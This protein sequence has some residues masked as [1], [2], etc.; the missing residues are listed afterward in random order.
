MTCPRVSAAAASSPVL[1]RKLC[2]KA[3]CAP[4]NLNYFRV[5]RDKTLPF[6]SHT[7][8]EA[9]P[10][11]C[12]KGQESLCAGFCRPWKWRTAATGA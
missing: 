10:G 2:L 9:S 6:R 8:S 11:R 5:P 12:R 7:A 3:T 4:G 1:T